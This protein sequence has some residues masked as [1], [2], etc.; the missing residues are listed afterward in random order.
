MADKLVVEMGERV[1]LRLEAFSR[2]GAVVPIPEGLVVGPLHFRTLDA[3]VGAVTRGV[4][5]G[6][7]EFWFDP[8]A[9][10]VVDVICEAQVAPPGRPPGSV[11]E[12]ARMSIEVNAG[13]FDHWGLAEV[14][15]ESGGGA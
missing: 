14:K 4:N 3:A 15:R 10:G 8:V 7:R 1:L 5:D 2:Y 13:A 6:P 12:L 9:P 11:G